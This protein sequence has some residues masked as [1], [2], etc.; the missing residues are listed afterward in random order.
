M[1]HEFGE[2]FRKSASAATF[3]RSTDG[4]IAD[5]DESVETGVLARPAAQRSR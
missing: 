5:C 2:V 3:M 1:C 4:R